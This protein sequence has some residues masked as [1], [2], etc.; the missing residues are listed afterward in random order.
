M[1]CQAAC[2]QVF[3]VAIINGGNA[4]VLYFCVKEDVNTC[5]LSLFRTHIYYPLPIGWQATMKSGTC[6]FV[7][8][9][10]CPC[11]FVCVGVVGRVSRQMAD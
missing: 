3:I 4:L 2:T 8:V 1:L 9:S 11:L 7:H 5:L 10:V 6:H